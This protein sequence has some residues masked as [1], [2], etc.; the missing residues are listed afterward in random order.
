MDNHEQILDWLRRNTRIPP[1]VLEQARA[2]A[3]QSGESL[4]A[5]LLNRGLLSGEQ[6]HQFLASPQGQ[7]PSSKSLRVFQGYEG[8]DRYEI[9]SELGQGGM[10]KVYLAKAR[11]TGLTVVIK[12]MIKMKNSNR[13]IERFRRE[14]LALARL[15]HPN[16]A[17][18]YDFRL[19]SQESVEHS[20]PY[21]VMEHIKGQTLGHAVEA[22]HRGSAEIPLDQLEAFFV[23]LARALVHC[24]ENGLVHRDLKP[25]NVLIEMS[26]DPEQAPRPVLIDFGLVKIDKE[27]LRQSLELSQQLTQSG[28][29]LGSPAF[30]APEQLHGEVEEVGAATDVWGFGATLY[31]AVSGQFPY[32]AHGLYDLF[33]QSKER[34]PKPLRHHDPSCPLWL[35]QICR[36]CLQRNP[37]LRPDLRE[38]I[39][40]FEERTVTKKKALSAR[41]LAA[42]ALLIAGLSL[43]A[44]VLLNQGGRPQLS[45]ETKSFT[46]QK[47]QLSL[48]GQILSDAPS[49]LWLQWS[50]KKSK[51]AFEVGGDGYFKIPIEL[52]EGK[53]TLTVTAEDQSGQFSKLQQ[54]IIVKDSR[55]P[56][57][58]NLNY[59]KKV[60]DANLLV[61]GQV[62]EPVTLFFNQRSITVDN[63]RFEESLPLKLGS[64]R[65]EIKAIDR[66]GNEVIQRIGV[67]RLP[68]LF[69]VQAADMKED[70]HHFDSLQKAVSAAPPFSRIQIAP[71][72]YDSGF[73]VTK[74]LSFLGQGVRS[75][76]ILRSRDAPFVIAAPDVTIEKVRIENVGLRNQS[77]ALHIFSSRCLIRDCSISSKTRQGVNIG[78]NNKLHTKKTVR[79]TRLENCSLIDCGQSGI[80]INDNA[81]VTVEACEMTQ[82]AK[83]GVFVQQGSKVHFARSTLSNNLLGLRVDLS[84]EVTGEDLKF[85]GNA[86]EGLS[87]ETKSQGSFKNCQFSGNGGFRRRLKYTQVRAI[88]ESK[89]LLTDCILKDGAKDGVFANERSLIRLKKCT[90]TGHRRFALS[91][92]AGSEIKL[93]Q[94][95]LKDNARPN[96]VQEGGKISGQ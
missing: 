63:D 15:S 96:H 11:E 80:V 2:L 26:E 1:G 45:L 89:L 12:T 69:V 4:V 53:N 35:D 30:A 85:S 19:C 60:Y 58:S 64:N 40:A 29:M 78:Y 10:G 54:L 82:N 91:S 34:D 65:I 62:N 47:S 95:V 87:I 50:E 13:L 88:Y 83:Y 77:D 22:L 9:L 38:V 18:V 79:D 81:T 90:I 37:A 86:E 25:E 57:L 74:S 73:T 76:V 66:A 59:P 51:K 42:A 16:I 8:M 20:Y 70:G 17:R 49:R 33:S 84:A 68:T 55:P 41:L 21:L 94:C 39:R 28:Q 71:G 6:Y 36:L 23:P 44:M 48:K 5:L 52:V 92:R 46:T 32:D 75:K 3:A 31:W 56:I 61:K 7:A 27:A 24:H 67:K 72:V 43:F 93:F 14:G